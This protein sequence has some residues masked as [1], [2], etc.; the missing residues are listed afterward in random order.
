MRFFLKSFLLFFLN[1]CQAQDQIEIN[2]STLP[3]IKEEQKIVTGAEQINIYLSLLKNKTVGIV[4]NQTSIINDT[5]L[6]DSL[7]SHKISIKSVYSPEHGFRGDAD[8][9]EKLI[10]KKMIKQ[11]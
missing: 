11:V 7:L 5:H 10:P 8:A 3:I 6:V 4:A 1:S 9:G 2:E